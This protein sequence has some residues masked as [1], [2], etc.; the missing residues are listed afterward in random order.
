MEIT[1]KID[2]YIDSDLFRGEIRSIIDRLID[3]QGQHSDKYTTIAVDFEVDDNSI[4]IHLNG[5]RPKTQKDI[6]LEKAQL[7]QR[8]EYQ[9]VRD[10]KLYEQLK[11][12]FEST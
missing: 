10:L 3:I 1:E 9:R 12:K 2:Y 11:A 8:E 4:E 6:N 5:T 7:K